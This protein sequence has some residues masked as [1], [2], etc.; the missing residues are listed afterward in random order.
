MGDITRANIKYGSIPHDDSA[1]LNIPDS[2]VYGN[3]K[4]SIITSER[5]S[6]PSTQG[7]T[8]HGPSQVGVFLDRGAD[9][10]IVAGKAA[11]TMMKPSPTTP[12]YVR[13]TRGYAPYQ[14]DCN[15]PGRVS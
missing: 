11:R 15:L 1:S 9:D 6:G 13:E 8:V 14:V 5:C 7:N 4:H 2:T 10:G 12:V 3:A